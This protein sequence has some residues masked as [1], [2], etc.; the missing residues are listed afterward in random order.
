MRKWCLEL[1]LSW[2][3]FQEDEEFKSLAL[4]CYVC[5]AIGLQFDEDM[6]A[7]GVIN[8]LELIVELQI[9]FPVELVESI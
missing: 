8:D 4:G 7:F 5:F 1:L 6:N 2:I 3:Y 9:H